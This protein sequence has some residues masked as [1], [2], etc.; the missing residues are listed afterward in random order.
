MLVGDR[1]IDEEL[2]VPLM[3]QAVPTEGCDVVQLTETRVSVGKTTRTVGVMV[4]LG[5]AIANKLRIDLVQS[6]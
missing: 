6:L 2:P 4:N 3:S 1:T 5:A